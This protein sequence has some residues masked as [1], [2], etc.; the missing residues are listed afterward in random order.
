M[1]ALSTDLEI[2]PTL[3]VGVKK[4]KIW[5]LRR[6]GFEA[7][8]RIAYVFQDYERLWWSSDISVYGIDRSTQLGET[9]FPIHTIN[10]CA[11]FH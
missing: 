2:W 6:C 11:K 4:C 10:I 8:Q 5:P 3:L 9:T 7:K 1:I